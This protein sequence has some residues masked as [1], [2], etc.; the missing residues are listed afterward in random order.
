MRKFITPTIVLIFTVGA[1]SACG[2]QAAEATD[3]PQSEPVVS[4]S[5]T[6]L[7]AATETVAP[8]ATPIPSET[9][10]PTATEVTRFIQ[11]DFSTKSDI[12]GDCLKCEWRDG[13]VL[14]GPIP[15]VGAGVDQIWYVICEACGKHTYYR[16]AA[17]VTFAEGYGLYRTFGILAG[18]T[19]N[20]FL[21]AGT[22]SATQL[23]LYESFDFNT[24]TW[25]EFL[26]K[27]YG[28]VKPGYGTNR[29][30]V[31]ITPSS[32]GGH[33]DIYLNINGTNLVVL[34]NQP[35][36]PTKVGLYLGWHSVGVLYDNFEYEVLDPIE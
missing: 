15:A 5:D 7:P 36:E 14:F 30:E 25:G 22:V 11:D 10:L 31:T 9:P 2:D 18:L 19:D 27:R 29:I 34:Y 33:A 17:D 32:S 16:V 26:V 1:L 4:P 23:A 6:P 12:W 24:N 20:G 8:T 3:T 28:S 35:V 21:Y 13:E